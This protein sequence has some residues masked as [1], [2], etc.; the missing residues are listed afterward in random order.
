MWEFTNQNFVDFDTGAVDF[1]ALGREEY[2]FRKAMFFKNFKNSER[3]RQSYIEAKQVYEKR[4]KAGKE[5][6]RPTNES[7]ARAANVI[8]F[9]K[10][11]PMP[12]EYRAVMDFALENN[13]DEA[14]VRECWE[15]TRERGWRDADGRPIKDWK[16]FVFKWVGTRV[17]NFGKQGEA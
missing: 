4:V 1:E 15:A 7:K 13:L 9:G 12:T 17:E 2:E 8:S 10:S 5:G 14:F 16:G 11:G 6:G 3:A